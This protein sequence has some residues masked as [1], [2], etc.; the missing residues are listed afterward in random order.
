MMRCLNIYNEA[1]TF[2]NIIIK[3]S[4]RRFFFSNTVGSLFFK[5]I[6]SF[7]EVK[8]NFPRTEA[9]NQYQMVQNNTNKLVYWKTRGLRH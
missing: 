2:R 4:T 1:H 6:L 5:T 8:N 7:F 3:L 9:E